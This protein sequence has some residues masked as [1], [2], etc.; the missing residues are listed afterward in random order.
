ML[1]RRHALQQPI[2]QIRLHP[3]YH[4]RRHASTSPPKDVAI[5][6]G[7]ITGLATAYYLSRGPNPPKVTIY[8]ASPRVGGQSVIIGIV[9]FVY[10]LMG[11]L[12]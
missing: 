11:M 4:A 7:G 8:E 2:K 10:V 3:S 12:T 6:G 5:L 9:L 1:L